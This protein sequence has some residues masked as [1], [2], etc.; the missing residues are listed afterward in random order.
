MRLGETRSRGRIAVILIAFVAG[1]QF[2]PSAWA[3]VVPEEKSQGTAVIIALI[4]AGIA[5]M[6][7]FFAT[8]SLRR[9]TRA[10]PARG[11]DGGDSLLAMMPAMGA[12][13]GKAK[14]HTHDDDGRPS[15]DTDAGGSDAGSGDGGGG[16]GGGGD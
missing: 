16:D 1:L 15:S 13:G 9:K 2:A 14:A 10:A 4:A 5:L 8:R 3:D 6:V 11:E 7:A 12:T